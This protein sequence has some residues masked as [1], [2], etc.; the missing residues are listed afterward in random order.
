MSEKNVNFTSGFGLGFGH[1]FNY[2]PKDLQNEI[3][4]KA[5]HDLQ[6]S[7]GLDQGLGTALPSLPE[8]IILPKCREKY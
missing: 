2:L 7:R 3:F 5:E 4:S 1:I 6:L 8:N